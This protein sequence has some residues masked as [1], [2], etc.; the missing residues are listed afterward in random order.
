MNGTLTYKLSMS[1]LSATPTIQ[2]NCHG[3]SRW[4]TRSG[5]KSINRL[6]CTPN[7]LSWIHFLDASVQI[8]QTHKLIY[9]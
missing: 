7:Y 8:L 3:D 1:F 4:L 5:K 2:N 6:L 9:T